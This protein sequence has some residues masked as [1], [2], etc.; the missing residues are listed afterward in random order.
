M[1]GMKLNLERKYGQWT[2]R[3]WGLILNLI[4]N[5]LALYGAVGVLKDGS[6]LPFLIIGLIIT[7]FCIVILSFPDL[8][9][10]G[11]Q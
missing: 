8:R 4:G 3:V 1:V 10:D 5:A 11:E 2:L 6:R 9:D 7:L